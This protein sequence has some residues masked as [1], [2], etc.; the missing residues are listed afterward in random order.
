[1]SSSVNSFLE[2][3]NVY[4]KEHI[5][6]AE[7]SFFFFEDEYDSDELQ[8]WFIDCLEKSPKLMSMRLTIRTSGL[9]KHR[10]TA[11]T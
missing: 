11:V 7:K 8:Q 1:V 2:A 6:N 10:K 3:Q 9:K 5:D 4:M